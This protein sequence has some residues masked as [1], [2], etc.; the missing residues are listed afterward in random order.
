MPLLRAGAA[1]FS[2]VV[3]HN[4]MHLGSSNAS[5]IAAIFGEATG[6]KYLVNIVGTGA[7]R[8]T[9]RLFGPGASA[10]QTLEQHTLFGVYCRVMSAHMADTLAKQLIAGDGTKFRKGFRG[11]RRRQIPKLATENLRSCQKCIEE[12]VETQG[13]TSWR[14]LVIRFNSQSNYYIINHMVLLNII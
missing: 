2:A 3:V 8:A 5:S 11:H 13:F 4:R 9:E 6:S 14:V 1:L 10:R 12:D 7:G